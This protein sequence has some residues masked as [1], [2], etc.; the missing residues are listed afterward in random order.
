MLTTPESPLTKPT[1]DL[2]TAIS[3]LQWIDDTTSG[4]VAFLLLTH[5]PSSCPSDP[6][7]HL[8]AQM[9]GLAA[10]LGLAAPS[11]QMPDIGTRLVAHDADIRLCLPG[12]G[13]VLRV[14]V[15]APAWSQF[16]LN[17]GPVAVVL[18]LD[19]FEPT[20]DRAQINDY[21]ATRALCDRLLMGKAIHRP[22][23]TSVTGARK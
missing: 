14:P 1:S 15:P 19:P 9:R 4:H 22:G 10:D 2:L 18:G 23:S 3:A 21:L 16:V 13:L 17:G 7:E 6:Q 12:S 8:E 11:A 5:P 20:S